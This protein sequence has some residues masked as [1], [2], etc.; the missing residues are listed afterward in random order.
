MSLIATNQYYLLYRA[1]LLNGDLDEAYELLDLGGQPSPIFCIDEHAC[2]VDEL[3]QILNEMDFSLVIHSGILCRYNYLGT[4]QQEE[5]AKVYKNLKKLEFA[6]TDRGP[7]KHIA[8]QFQVI[9]GKKMPGENHNFQRGITM[10]T[11]KLLNDLKQEFSY[12]SMI[13][14]RAIHRYLI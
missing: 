5:Q 11:Q 6:L 14:E 3:M 4:N 12:Q 10:S 8:R 13:L 7:Y 1:T 9:A 2:K